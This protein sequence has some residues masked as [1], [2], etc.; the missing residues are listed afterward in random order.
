MSRDGQSQIGHVCDALP[1]AGESDE[2][3]LGEE[4][5]V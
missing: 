2:E 1:E 4:H 5:R 3:G